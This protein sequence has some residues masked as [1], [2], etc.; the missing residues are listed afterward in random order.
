MRMTTTID[1]QPHTT[2]APDTPEEIIAALRADVLA[3]EP[4]Y[5]ALLRAIGRWR[6]PAERV[7]D[8]QYVYL[9][10]GEAFDWLLLAER[11][12]D[13]VADLVPE[14]EREAL[15]F[16]ARVPGGMDDDEFRRLIGPA[17]YRAH[18]NFLYGVLVEETLQLT[19]EEDL[20]K[21]ARCRVW[22]RD[23][24][25]DETVYERLYRQTRDALLR[26][27]RAERGLPHTP[28]ITLTELREFTYWLFKL[29]LRVS[30][31]ALVAS[32][33]RRALAR[34]S[35][36]ELHRRAQRGDAPAA[37]PLPR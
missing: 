10:G 3:G 29:R 27:F 6:L 8:R 32:D 12:T 21:E 5:P 33:T 31:P 24:R 11:L 15:L 16:H 1:G 26:E 13:A 17:K 7:G 14:E 19:V 22:G 23:P 36:L 28:V 30:D 35:E 9:I 18:L 25:V 2:D 37:D 34:L 4:W 20:H